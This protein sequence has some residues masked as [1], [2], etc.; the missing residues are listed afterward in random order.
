MTP[1]P[2]PTK[3]YTPNVFDT[4]ATPTPGSTIKKKTRFSD[5]SDISL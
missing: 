4:A 2:T 3:Q 5:G 1:T